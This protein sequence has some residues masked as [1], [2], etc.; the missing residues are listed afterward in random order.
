VLLRG[1]ELDIRSTQIWVSPMDSSA[2]I[3]QLASEG[4]SFGDYCLQSPDY[5]APK[6]LD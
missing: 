5:P 4:S 3:S 2:V 1:V 6:D